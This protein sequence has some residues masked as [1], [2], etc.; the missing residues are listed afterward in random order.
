MSMGDE[1]L[2]LEV[3]VTIVIAVKY[4][5][6]KIGRLSGLVVDAKAFFK[7]SLRLYHAET[8]YCRSG[9]ARDKVALE[10]PDSKGNSL[11]ALVP[12]WFVCTSPL[13]GLAISIETSEATRLAAQLPRMRSPT[14]RPMI[15][16]R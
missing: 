1:M 2:I 8:R 10:V 3:F 13:G 16:R 14:P 12:G 15:N 6:F 9:V 7:S 4:M 11:A 5:I